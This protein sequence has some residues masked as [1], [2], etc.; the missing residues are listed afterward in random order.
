MIC[1]E[2]GINKYERIFLYL[3]IFSIFHIVGS[4][5]GHSTSICNRVRAL[6]YSPYRAKKINTKISNI[7]IGPKLFQ[8][9]I[10]LFEH[11]GQM[12]LMSGQL[13]IKSE[14]DESVLQPNNLQVH[15]PANCFINW[16]KKISFNFALCCSSEI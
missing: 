14:I 12:E 2:W 8:Y 1:S 15:T 9:I 13:G 6:P 3:F 5:S 4:L 7:S 10:P 11:F 16:V